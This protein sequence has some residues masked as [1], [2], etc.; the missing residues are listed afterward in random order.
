VDLGVPRSSRGSGTIKI[1]SLLGKIPAYEQVN[2]E[3]IGA[4]AKVMPG[5]LPF[6]VEEA[7][8]SRSHGS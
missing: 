8:L 6:R 4:V 2:Q 1:K 7:I 3:K 5:P